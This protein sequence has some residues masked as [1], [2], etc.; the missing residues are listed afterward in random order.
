MPLLEGANLAVGDWRSEHELSLTF[1]AM[2]RRR[3]EHVLP[4]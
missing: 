1:G 2:K 3:L 4:A